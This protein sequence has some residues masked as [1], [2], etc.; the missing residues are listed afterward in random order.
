MCVIIICVCVCRQDARR[1][2]QFRDQTSNKITLEA[3]LNTTCSK[4]GCKGTT[5]TRLRVSYHLGWLVDC[6]LKFLKS[7]HTDA[8]FFNK[9]SLFSGHFT[10]DCFSAPGLQYALVPEEG[11]DEPVREPSTVTPQPQ[12]SSKKKKKKV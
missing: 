10:K 5:T 1:R 6:W 8:V 3:V 11:D 7:L 12:D 4:C 2:R 9:S